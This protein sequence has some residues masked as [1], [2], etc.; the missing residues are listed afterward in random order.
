M[1]PRMPEA[2]LHRSAYYW[3]HPA[4]NDVSFSA[5]LQLHEASPGDPL[6]SC[7]SSLFAP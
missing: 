1:A 7:F 3:A 2:I 4:A 5:R 6:L